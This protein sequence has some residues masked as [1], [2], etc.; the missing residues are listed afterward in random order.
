[1]FSAMELLCFRYIIMIKLHEH[2]LLGESH[3][4]ALLVRT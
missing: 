3:F 4:L 1:M 2:A